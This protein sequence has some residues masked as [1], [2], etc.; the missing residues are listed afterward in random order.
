MRGLAVRS[1]L[2]LDVTYGFTSTLTPC[3]GASMPS[4]RAA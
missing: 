4:S 2:T 3:G 1:E